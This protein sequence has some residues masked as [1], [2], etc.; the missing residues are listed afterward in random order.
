M[1]VIVSIKLVVVVKSVF[2]MVL[3]VIQC[4]KK[5]KKQTN[6]KKTMTFKIYVNASSFERDLKNVHNKKGYFAYS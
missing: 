6:S 5:T 2:G 1:L 4:W 3:N